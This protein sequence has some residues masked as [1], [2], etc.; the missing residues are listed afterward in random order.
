MQ[1][2]LQAAAGSAGTP[3]T[4]YVAPIPLEGGRHRERHDKVTILHFPLAMWPPRDLGGEGHLGLSGYL[5]SPLPGECPCLYLQVHIPKS[6]W[7][8]G[9][10]LG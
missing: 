10:H 9:G 2:T 1:A 6:P 4:T 5:P 8:G 3:L 7:P